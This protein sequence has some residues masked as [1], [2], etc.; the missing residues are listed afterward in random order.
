MSNMNATDLAISQ[1]S[2]VS[3][4]SS[5]FSLHIKLSLDLHD[6]VASNAVLVDDMV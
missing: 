6:A 2:Q 4:L 1:G 5:C 3:S